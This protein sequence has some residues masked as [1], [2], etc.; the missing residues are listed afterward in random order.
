MIFPHRCGPSRTP[1]S[2]AHRRPDSTTGDHLVGR[3]RTSWALTVRSLIVLDD[4]SSLEPYRAMACPDRWRCDRSGSW[5]AVPGPLSTP[6][7]RPW[8]S[9]YS[10]AVSGNDPLRGLDHRTDCPHARLLP[11]VNRARDQRMPVASATQVRQPPARVP[12]HPFPQAKRRSHCSPALDYGTRAH[13]FRQTRV[14]RSLPQSGKVKRLLKCAAGYP[15][16][17]DVPPHFSATPDP[18]GGVT[19]LS[20]GPQQPWQ[21]CLW[22]VWASW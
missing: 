13:L 22:A 21:V 6:R 16:L 7:P 4:P 15:C 5:P 18:R 10:L 11:E 19:G 12:L 14:H 1:R 3:A 9:W 17:A 20:R 2:G 8:M